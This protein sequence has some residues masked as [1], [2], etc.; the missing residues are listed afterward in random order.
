MTAAGTIN[1]DAITVTAATDTKTYD[2]TTTS[3]AVPIVTGG[4]GAGDT[5][6]FSQA[7]DSP[8]A[9][10]R[11]LT[12]SGIVNDGNGGSQLHVHVR[13]GRRHDQSARPSP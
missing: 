3:S 9:G 7:F 10:S 1:Q 11:T 13:D 12:A 6:G 2:G 5:P 8:D 4:L